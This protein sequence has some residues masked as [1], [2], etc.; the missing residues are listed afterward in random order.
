[1]IKIYNRYIGS[2]NNFYR[3]DPL[4]DSSPGRK[5]KAGQF[6]GKNILSS[7]TNNILGSFSSVLPAGLEISD[8]LIFVILLLLYLESKDEDFLII[9]AVLA[10]S[11]LKKD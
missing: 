6:N 10:F 1:M 9:L 4:F 5:E 3:V 7:H 2:S 8:I 11:V